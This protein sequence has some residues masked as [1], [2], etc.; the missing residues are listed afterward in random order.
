MFDRACTKSSVVRSEGRNDLAQYS[1]DPVLPH[2]KESTHNGLPIQR[3]DDGTLLEVDRPV[4]LL[5]QNLART[6]SEQ[7]M[8]GDLKLERA[9]VP[10]LVQRFVVLVQEREDL[11]RVLGRKLSSFDQPP[12][13][14]LQDRR[15]TMLESETFL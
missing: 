10:R 14:S 15:R 4:L 2:H 13:V 9:N 11:V 8:E 5:G 6:V 1:S 7:L 12:I 3:V